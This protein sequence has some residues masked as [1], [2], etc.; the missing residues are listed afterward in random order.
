MSGLARFTFLWQRD[1]VYADFSCLLT[2]IRGMQD[3]NFCSLS[4]LFSVASRTN[5]QIQK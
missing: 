4:T 3:E 5:T 2:L 1:R